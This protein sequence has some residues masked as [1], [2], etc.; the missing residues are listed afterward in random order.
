M[1][2]EMKTI[3][4]FLFFMCSGLTLFAQKEN[5]I[6]LHVEAGAKYDVKPNHYSGYDFNSQEKGFSGYQLF[7]SG[8]YPMNERFAAGVGAGANVYT[9]YD[10]YFDNITSFPVYANAVYKLLPT[11]RDFVPFIDVKVGYGIISREYR[12]THFLEIYPEER[13][14]RNVKNS[15]GLYVS[16]SIGIM[17][18]WDDRAFTLSLS[19][20]L[21][22]MKSKLTDLSN[23]TISTN[24]K[25]HTNTLALRIGFMF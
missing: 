18:P 8:L 23:E 1:N 15:G 24:T 13:I 19:Y 10:E 21:Q 17:F 2:N 14:D 20:D 16:P 12:V 25:T 7:V 5:R 11:S 22:T 6:V 9:R 4:L 3:Y